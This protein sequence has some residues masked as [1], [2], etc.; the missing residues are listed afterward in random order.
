MKEVRT[1]GPHESTMTVEM[2]LF[3]LIAVLLIGL[4]LNQVLILAPLNWL[5]MLNVSNW[6]I[7]ALLLALFAWCFGE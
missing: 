6:I 7:L 2:S 4:V 3:T 5:H 1:P